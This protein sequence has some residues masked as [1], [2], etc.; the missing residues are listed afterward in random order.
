[1]LTFGSL[2]PG[3]HATTING[4]NYGVISPVSGA[5]VTIYSGNFTNNGNVPNYRPLSQ[6]CILGGLILVRTVSLKV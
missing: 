3:L 1:M 4:G 2:T 6:L 5:D